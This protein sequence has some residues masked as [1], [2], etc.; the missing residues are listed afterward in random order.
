MYDKGVWRGIQNQVGS[1]V[2]LNELQHLELLPSSRPLPPHQVGYLAAIQ[3]GIHLQ[4]QVV[5]LVPPHYKLLVMLLDV[6][7]PH[8]L[9]VAPHGQP[10]HHLHPLHRHSLSL[11]RLQKGL[12]QVRILGRV[13][14]EGEEDVVLGDLVGDAEGL[15][16]E[17]VLLDPLV[18]EEGVDA[19]LSARQH[20]DEGLGLVLGDGLLQLFATWLAVFDED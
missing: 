4:E 14:A 15:A 9:E 13:A 11:H 20:L 7:T 10:I 1:P 19:G 2:E 12:L 3:S 8:L 6:E 17:D 16:D 5:T 18:D